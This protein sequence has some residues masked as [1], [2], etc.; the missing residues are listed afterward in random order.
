MTWKNTIPFGRRLVCLC[1]IEP[2]QPC[3]A[4]FL[5]PTDICRPL[6]QDGIL[7]CAGNGPVSKYS[8]ACFDASIN[9]PYRLNLG[10]FAIS[11][12]CFSPFTKRSHQ[13]I[14]EKLFE[15]V[16][17]LGCVSC[18]M[19]DGT[20]LCEARA[21]TSA[22]WLAPRPNGSQRPWALGSVGSVGS[23]S[24]SHFLARGVEVHESERLSP[25]CCVLPVTRPPPKKHPF[26]KTPF[27]SWDLLVLGRPLDPSSC[28]ML[29]PRAM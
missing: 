13:T 25:S 11:S 15:V 24:T 23:D 1:L 3:Q 4:H 5:R 16:H 10:A 28:V 2:V 9:H 26:P 17:G 8:Q 19:R 27:S 29:L 14:S 21:P 18:S 6:N 12:L 20:E 7:S 22:L